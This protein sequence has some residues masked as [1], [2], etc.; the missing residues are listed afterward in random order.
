MASPR[1][2]IVWFQRLAT[3]SYI[4]VSQIK[5][6]FGLSAAS[7]EEMMVSDIWARVDVDFT[8]QQPWDRVPI[9]QLNNNN[10]K[11]AFPSN[12]CK[13]FLR[14]LSSEVAE[15]KAACETPASATDATFKND[16]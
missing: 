6:Y 10:N 8:L 4:G 13:N 12:I 16:F 2:P 11:K 15:H 14:S 1:N 9:P 7:F 5:L 3:T